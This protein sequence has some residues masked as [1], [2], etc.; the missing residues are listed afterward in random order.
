MFSDLAPSDQYPIDYDLGFFT[1]L[2]LQ[3]VLKMAKYQVTFIFTLSIYLSTF[4]N[5]FRGVALF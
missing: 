5:I 1:Y 4:M 2:L 3:H